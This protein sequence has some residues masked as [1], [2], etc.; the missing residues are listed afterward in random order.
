MAISGLYS[1]HLKVLGMAI[2]SRNNMVISLES[3]EVKFLEDAMDVSGRETDVWHKMG[4]EEPTAAER[5]W[6]E[7][8]R[9]PPASWC[10]SCVEGRVIDDRHLPRSKERNNELEAP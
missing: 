5:S 9:F 8:A 2:G 10:R 7:L 3:D 4:P 6:H 1:L